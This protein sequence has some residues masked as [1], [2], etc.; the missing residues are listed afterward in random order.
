MFSNQ[1]IIFQGFSLLNF[2]EKDAKKTT[3]DSYSRDQ[4]QKSGWTPTVLP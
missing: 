1:P 3:D 2:Q 4:T